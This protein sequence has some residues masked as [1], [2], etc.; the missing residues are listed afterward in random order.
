MD[1]RTASTKPTQLHPCDCEEE[2]DEGEGEW[3]AE[4][5]AL[6]DDLIAQHHQHAARHIDGCQSYGHRTHEL[7][8]RPFR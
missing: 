4:G 8:K 7:S 3:G 5:E 1:T 2:V 6:E